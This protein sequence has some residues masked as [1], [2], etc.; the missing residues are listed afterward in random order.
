MQT[1]TNSFRDENV[2]KIKSQHH[3]N[4]KSLSAENDNL[5]HR[6]KQLQSDLELHKESLDYTVRY[7]IDLEKAIEEKTYYQRELD[8]LKSEKDRIEEEKLEYKIKYHSLQEEIRLILLDRSKL[9]QKLTGELQGHFQEKQQSTDDIKKY[10]TQIEQLNIKLDDAEARLV[11]LQT[12]NQT[13]LTS[14]DHHITEQRYHNHTKKQV[15][16]PLA[17]ITSTP[18]PNKSQ[19][20]ILTSSLHPQSNIVEENHEFNQTYPSNENYLIHNSRQIRSDTERV[21]FEL[22][23]LRQDFDRLVSNYEPINNYHHQT[24]LHSQIDTFRH[25]YQQEFQQRQL[26][27]SKLP[28]ER[29]PNRRSSLNG[30]STYTDS[31]L[32][33]ERLESAI[34][35]SLSEQR[36]QTITQLPRQASALLTINTTNNGLMSSVELFRN[37]YNA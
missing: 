15:Y 2:D 25:F 32:F 28:V 20:R 29:T 23:R 3:E 34:D 33:K 36:L 13:L 5:Y 4:M 12:Q 31:R 22:D 8:R 18:L 6:T 21:K 26:L 19:H 10:R 17:I 16:E 14:K 1:T 30:S 35:T 24:K 37:H 9:E 11:D 27:M 7:K